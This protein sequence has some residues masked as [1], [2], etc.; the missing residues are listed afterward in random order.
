MANKKINIGV[1]GLGRIG[2]DYHC[3]ELLKQS[4]NYNLVAVSDVSI[5]R[6]EE[7]RDVLFCDAY[8]KYEDFLN[9]PD[10]E[11]VVIASPTHLHKAMSIK[12]FQKGLHVLLEKPMA[13]N[14]KEAK[15]MIDAAA[16]HKVKFTIYQPARLANYFQHVLQI[17]DSKV[18]GEIY[19]VK[20][21]RMQFSRRNDWQSLQ[22]FNG[23]MLSNYG[24]HLI[25]QLLHIIG[26]DFQK[27]FCTLR[28]V[29]TLG[30]ADDVV[31]ITTQTKK[32]KIGEVDINSASI[33]NPNYLEIYGTTGVIT[34]HGTKE[35][36]LQTFLKKDLPKKKLESSLTAKD[37]KYPNDKFP[38]KEKRIPVN[39]KLEISIYDNFYKSIR[40][41]KPLAIKAT[42]VYEVMK[43]MDL[44]R[45]EAGKILDTK[46]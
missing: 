32:G 34:M 19:Q 4:K 13:S 44:C 28:R 43:F 25:D 8:T 38:R 45:K 33:G 30:D 1:V 11:A 41:N 7:A 16:K 17:L 9:H 26:T 22:K 6:C 40:L 24:G 5:E 23:G 3:L 10:L 2:W 18:I 15:A 20:I 35:I 29:A 27:T 37:R 31:K 21:C 36:L 39:P 14:A 12:A 42:E 46:I